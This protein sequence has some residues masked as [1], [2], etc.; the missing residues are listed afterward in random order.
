MIEEIPDFPDDDTPIY[1]QLLKETRATEKYEAI[2][3]DE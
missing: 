3:E 1:T 2:F